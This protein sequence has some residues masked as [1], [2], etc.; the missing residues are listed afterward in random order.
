MVRA[1]TARRSSSASHPVPRRLA[2]TQPRACRCAGRSRIS[3]DSILP[4]ALEPIESQCRI[5]LHAHDRAAAKIALDCPCILAIVSE[6]IA[7]AVT[8][9]PA[10]DQEWELGGLAR[11]CHHALITSHR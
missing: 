5:A 3:R 11:P 1:A 8:Q 2:A 4:E 10:V 9:H 7:G 6:F